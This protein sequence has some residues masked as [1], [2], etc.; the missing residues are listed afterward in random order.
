MLSFLTLDAVASFSTLGAVGVL[1]RVEPVTDEA[2]LL[3]RWPGMLTLSVLSDFDELMAFDR[4]GISVSAGL[5]DDD[6][7]CDAWV[8]AVMAVSSD[9]VTTAV[10]P[11]DV[12]VMPDEAAVVAT[13]EAAR[14]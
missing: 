9:V 8:D 5:D 3:W 2:L 7:S 13:T 11:L 14:G 1:D 4:S 6:D 10:P 12:N